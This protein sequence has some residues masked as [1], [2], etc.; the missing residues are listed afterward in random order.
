MKRVMTHLVP[1]QEITWATIMEQ[2]VTR[3]IPGEEA[4]ALHALIPQLTAHGEVTAKA[5]SLLVQAAGKPDQERK[6][7]S[8]FFNWIRSTYKLSPHKK[9]EKFAQ[10]IREMRWDWKSNPVDKITGILAETQLTLEELI[11]QPALREELEAVMASKLN[12]TLKLEITQRSPEEWKQAITEIW[13]S[14]KNVTRPK[15]H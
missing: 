10:K 5:T 4:L 7:L 3:G 14:V 15:W 12:I 2:V 6:T 1:G 8:D 11:N 13:E 9:R